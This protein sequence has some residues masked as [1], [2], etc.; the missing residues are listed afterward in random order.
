[1]GDAPIAVAVADFNGDGRLDLVAANQTPSTASVLLGDGAGG[2]GPAAEF[3]VGSHPL[4]SDED[5][6]RILNAMAVPVVLSGGVA[7]RWESPSGVA[8]GP[9]FGAAAETVVRPPSETLIV[10]TGCEHAPALGKGSPEAR[11]RTDRF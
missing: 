1:M 6:C 3:P 9:A 2:F 10:A 5:R 8:A 11:L 4:A 7:R